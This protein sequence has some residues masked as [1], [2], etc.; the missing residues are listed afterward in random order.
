VSIK[1]FAGQAISE[2]VASV[3][4]KALE[5]LTKKEIS[6]LVKRVE[7]ILDSGDPLAVELLSTTVNFWERQLSPQ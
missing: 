5:P 2:A 1:D 3:G 6:Q 4:E 7:R